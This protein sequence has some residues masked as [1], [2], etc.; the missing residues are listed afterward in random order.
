MKYVLATILVVMC[1]SC[2]TI[3]NVMKGM[4]D[5]LGNAS[6]TPRQRVTT[7]S[8]EGVQ[9]FQTYVCR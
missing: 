7:C 2:S 8:P 5:A 4:G 6:Q 9:P 3:S 1:S